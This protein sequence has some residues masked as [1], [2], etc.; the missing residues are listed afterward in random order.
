MWSYHLLAWLPWLYILLMPMLESDPSVVALSLCAVALVAAFRLAFRNE[1]WHRW[2]YM[3]WF[4]YYSTVVGSWIAVLGFD[5][6]KR[7]IGGT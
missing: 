6:A 1:R 2:V 5:A 3:F 4:V 7:L